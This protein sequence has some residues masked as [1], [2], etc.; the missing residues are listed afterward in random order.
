MMGVLWDVDVLAEVVFVLH[1]IGQAF[2]GDVEQ[3]DVGLHVAVFQVL[4][5]DILESVDLGLLGLM[6]DGG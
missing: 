2:V 5:A 3:V 1:D 6:G 4:G